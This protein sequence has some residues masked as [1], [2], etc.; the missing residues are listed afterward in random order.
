MNKDTKLLREIYDNMKDTRMNRIKTFVELAQERIGKRWH[1]VTATMQEESGALED[2]VVLSGTPSDILILFKDKAIEAYP[3][4]E[5]SKEHISS[6][7]HS[8]EDYIELLDTI[9]EIGDED[10]IQ[11]SE[12]E[13]VFNK[14]MLNPNQSRINE[15]VSKIDP[16]AEI[17]WRDDQTLEIHNVSMELKIIDVLQKVVKSGFIVHSN[18]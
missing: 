4:Y 14:R 17:D 8:K 7:G 6:N 1:T 3:D 11:G 15:I 2:Y 9:L 16:M 5:N 10:Q 18:G 12:L 13:L